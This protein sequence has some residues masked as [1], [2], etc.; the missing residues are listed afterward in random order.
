MENNKIKLSEAIAIILAVF[1][2]HSILT[3]PKDILNITKSGTILNIIFVSVIALLVVTLVYKLMSKFKGEDILDIS[4][5]LGGTIFKNLI[6]FVFITYFLISSSL[7]LR[8]FSECLKII[9]FPVTDL[10]FIILSFVIVLCI[11]GKFKLNVIAKVSL[12]LAPLLII[13][14]LFIFFSNIGN[15]DFNNIFPIIGDSM[16]N[17]FILGLTNL[18]AFGGIAFIYFL[19]TL[20]EKNSDFKKVSILS[21]GIG[22]LYILLYISLILF[23]FDFL[24]EISELMPIYSASRYIE[25]GAFF[26]RLESSF[27][28]L[29]IMQIVCY[30]SLCLIFSLY[31][32]KK[33]TKIETKKPL[34]LS[35]CLIMFGISFSPK[36]YA[37]ATFF[38]SNIYEYVVLALSF[39]LIPSI[40]ILANLKKKI[41]EKL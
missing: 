25:Y 6:G 9:Y 4:E 32:F 22:A 10:I 35:F 29:W 28:L 14:I 21:I 16:F 33:I 34:V 36:N 12:M 11:V 23:M 17:T 5:Y 26:Q 3:I 18:G 38:Q 7:L 8:N 40:L 19:P 37:S 31:I 1:F 41:K 27:L 30:L 20:L 24:I 39:V 13:S 2:A 15:F